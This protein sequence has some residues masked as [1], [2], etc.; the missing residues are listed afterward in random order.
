MFSL[1]IPKI[2][3][4]PDLATFSTSAYSTAAIEPVVCTENVIDDDFGSDQVK[5]PTPCAR[6]P[7]SAEMQIEAQHCRNNFTRVFSM[8]HKTFLN[9]GDV[10]ITEACPELCGYFTFTRHRDHTDKPTR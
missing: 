2:P 3:F 8:C 5:F 1:P 7:C 6:I 9:A 4:S 10:L